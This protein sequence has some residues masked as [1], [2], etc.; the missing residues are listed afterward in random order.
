MNKV[1]KTNQNQPTQV[2]ENVKDP[3]KKL[4]DA[5]IAGDAM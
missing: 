3:E 1:C 5:S 2:T 4:F